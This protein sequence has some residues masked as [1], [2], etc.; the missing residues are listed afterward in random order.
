M[1]VFNTMIQYNARVNVGSRIA[2]DDGDVRISGKIVEIIDEMAIIETIGRGIIKRDLSFLKCNL[3]LF[4]FEHKNDIFE[5][6]C[7]G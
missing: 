2:W 1:E 3:L 6:R 4:T 5:I 7:I